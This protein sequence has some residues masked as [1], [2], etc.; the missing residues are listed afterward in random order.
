MG[1]HFFAK[2]PQGKMPNQSMEGRAIG[3]SA[4]AASR[5]A[6]AAAKDLGAASALNKGM[7]AQKTTGSSAYA[8]GPKKV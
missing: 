2:A 6:G 8:P 1:A 7:K 4:Y 5:N 3:T